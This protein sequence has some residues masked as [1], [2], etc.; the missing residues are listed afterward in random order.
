MPYY[1]IR[2]GF[3][4]THNGKLFHPGQQII[5]TE[6]NA[7]LYPHQIEPWI[8]KKERKKRQRKA[9]KQ[10]ALELGKQAVRIEQNLKQT[11]DAKG[12][13]KYRSPSFAVFCALHP[14]RTNCEGCPDFDPKTKQ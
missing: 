12:F 9:A 2:Q 4:L 7:K 3:Y 11:F 5:L 10:E 14:D 6:E 1:L 13:C 8:S